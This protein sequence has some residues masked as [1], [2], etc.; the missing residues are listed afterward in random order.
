MDRKTLMQYRALKKEIAGLDATIERLRKQ[1]DSVP[2]IMG[3]VQSS[4]RDYPYIRTHVAV[5][6]QDPEEM[7]RIRRLIRLKER[8]R[9]QAF[10]TLIRIELFIHSIQDS[11]DRQIFELVYIEGLTH[12]MVADSL[13]MERSSVSKRIDRVLQNSPNS[14]K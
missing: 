10:E 4:E 7:D 11:T 9:T 3:K 14:P 6:M 13:F 2:T 5:E 1:L 12:N 8:R